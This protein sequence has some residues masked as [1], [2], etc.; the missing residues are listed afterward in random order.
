MAARAMPVDE[1]TWHACITPPPPPHDTAGHWTCPTCKADWIW[2][3]PP[4]PAPQWI[5]ATPEDN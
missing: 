3:R 1:H 2:R 4:R 5:R